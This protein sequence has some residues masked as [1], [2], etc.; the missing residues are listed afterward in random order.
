MKSRELNKM[1]KIMAAW[2]TLTPTASF[3]GYTLAQFKA[4]LQPVFDQQS[5]LAGLNSQVTDARNQQ[6]V[7][8]VDCHAAMLL[9]VNA[10]KGDPAQGE[11]S[12]LYAAMGYVRKSDRKSGLARKAVK[13]AVATAMAA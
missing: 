3:G 8:I 5:R 11:D 7:A 12:S 10:V 1:N 6:Q 4:K 13:T 9:V 2:E